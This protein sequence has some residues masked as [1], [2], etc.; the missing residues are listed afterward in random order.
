MIELA[1]NRYGKAAIRLVRVDRD[2]EP[3]RVRDLTVAVGL[4]GAFEAAH[5]AGD[6]SAVIATDTMKNTVYALALDRLTGPLERFGL[7]LAEHFLDRATI[8]L[9][10]VTWAPIPAGA[11]PAPDAFVRDGTGVRVA[12]V[13]ADRRRTTVEAGVRDLTVMKTSRSSFAGFVRDRFTTLPDAAERILATDVRATW[14]YR[15]RPAPGLED[16]PEP[17]PG[18]EAGQGSEPEPHRAPD[19]DFDRSFE[20]I[21][22]TL[23]ETFADHDSPSVQATA[24]IV[25]RAVLE[26][27]P[28]VA[29]VRL[30]LPN[31][32]HW[33]VDLEPFGLRNEDVVYV[34]TRE[35]H[36]LIEATVRRTG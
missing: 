16:Q 29:E 36:G 17:A 20:A 4:E 18:A 19:L 33:L 9:E 12:E 23:L 26:R 5:T 22:A 2:R 11:R 1:E 25:G 27:H 10:E 15:D 13:V 6:N 28:E 30:R 14:R 21:R 3:H 32:H 35:P 34:P 7:A 31:L 8:G 24:W